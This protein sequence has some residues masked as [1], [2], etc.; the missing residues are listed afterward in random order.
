[1]AAPPAVRGV[2]LAP[3]PPRHVLPVVPRVA[4]L[5]GCLLT[6]SVHVSLVPSDVEHLPIPLGHP[7]VFLGK[8][9]TQV[10]CPFFRWVVWFLSLSRMSS[11]C[12]LDFP[13]SVGG[14]SVVRMASLLCRRLLVG[15]GPVRLVR[16]SPALLLGSSSQNPSE[17]GSLSLV[18]VFFYVFCSFRSST[19]VFN[20][21]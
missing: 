5:P 2:P 15:C 20:L 17:A 3:R 7:C 8:A 14:L 13:H 11:P 9:S 10:L 12:S 1:M 6:A 21:R 18:S 16:L 4:I 19:Q